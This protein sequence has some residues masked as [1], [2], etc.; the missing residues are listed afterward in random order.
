MLFVDFVSYWSIVF[1]QRIQQNKDHKLSQLEMKQVP[2]M[3]HQIQRYSIPSLKL[4]KLQE[5]NNET[6]T[7]FITKV[8]KT[9][10]HNQTTLHTFQFFT[11]IKEQNPKRF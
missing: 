9:H 8:F 7:K 4:K 11:E 5:S 3:H 10:H 2:P 6:N 1:S